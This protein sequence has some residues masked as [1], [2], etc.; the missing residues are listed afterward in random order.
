MQLLGQDVLPM[1]MGCWAIGGQFHAGM[2]PLGF[3]DIDDAESKR[4]IR[5]TLDAGLRIFD[6]AAFYGAGHSERLLGEA[7]KDQPDAIIMSKLGT[8]IDEDSRQILHAETEANAVIPA[9]EGSLRRLNRD[10]VD[11]MLLHLNAL[12]VSTARPIFEQMEI[13]RQAG[14]I[15]AY[16]WSTDFPES[17]KAMLDLEGFIGVEHAMNVFVDVPTI[18]STVRKNNLF[19]FLR[20]PLAMGL[21]TGKFD[22]T[23]V[24][25]D[26]DVRSV[27]SERRDYFED[28]KP[29]AAHLQNLASIRE[30]LRS[31]GR[32]FAQGALCWLLAKYDRNIP[33][34]GARTAEQ[35]AENAAALAF[36]PLSD[37]EM[38]EIETLMTRAPEGAP[39]AR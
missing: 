12:P 11:I 23:T 13:A 6:T 24:M 9:I 1:G 3:A 28:A 27:N 29:A 34:P 18:Q 32:T 16:G 5:A 33:L 22:D 38:S 25:P 37:N 7:L 26:T 8:A 39:R 2:V 4:A 36:G 17:T 14:N 31:D 21:L 15:R 35:A 10:H 20:S 30:I 19:A